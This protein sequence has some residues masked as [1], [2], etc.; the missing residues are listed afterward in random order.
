MNLSWLVWSGLDQSLTFFLCCLCVCVWPIS[1]P[2]LVFVNWD[3]SKP[4]TARADVYI[5]GLQ[6][7]VTGR[8]SAPDAA[9]KIKTPGMSDYLCCRLLPFPFHT[10]SKNCVCGTE[11]GVCLWAQKRTWESLGETAPGT[12]P[13]PSL[14]EA[15]AKL[16]YIGGGG[17]RVRAAGLLSLPRSP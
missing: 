10:T 3:L 17:S 6:V 5:R 2:L 15:R 4:N 13:L 12:S 8:Q 11:W 14:K 16:K 1:S 7:K 9:E